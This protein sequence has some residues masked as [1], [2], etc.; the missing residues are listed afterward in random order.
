MSE[1]RARDV[2]TKRA[3]ENSSSAIAK[4]CAGVMPSHVFSCASSTSAKVAGQNGWS[5]LFWFGG[6]S[7]SLDFSQLF[8]IGQV[9]MPADLA[10]HG[11]EVIDGAYADFD[12]VKIHE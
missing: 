12:P 11:D 3:N 1:F 4:R 7:I 6:F 5:A 10:L 9:Y 2:S 8:N